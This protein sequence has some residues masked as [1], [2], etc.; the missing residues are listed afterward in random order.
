MAPTGE[1]TC[2]IY[3]ELIDSLYAYDKYAEPASHDFWQRIA[4]AVD[5]LYWTIFG[6]EAVR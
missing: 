3:G 2:P 4:D 5:W 6:L 1:R